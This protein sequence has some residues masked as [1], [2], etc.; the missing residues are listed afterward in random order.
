M[1]QNLI[2]LTV[3]LALNTTLGTSYSHED[4]RHKK[5]EGFW[6]RTKEPDMFMFNPDIQDLADAVQNGRG[7]PIPKEIAQFGNN[8]TG[9]LQYIKN[10]VRRSTHGAHP[11]ATMSQGQFEHSISH[12]VN[13]EKVRRAYMENQGGYGEY[14]PEYPP[15][16]HYESHPHPH[17]EHPTHKKHIYSI[18]NPFGLPPA[19][20]SYFHKPGYHGVGHPGEY[21]PSASHHHG[22]SMKKKWGY[23]PRLLSAL[24]CPCDCHDWHCFWLSYLFFLWTLYLIYKWSVQLKMPPPVAKWICLWLAWFCIKRASP[25]AWQAV[26]WGWTVSVVGQFQ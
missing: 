11:P 10:R 13:K 18:D 22:Q 25:S 4:S 14:H 1:K 7:Y 24:P 8:L 3:L 12:I 20:R 6:K 16:H 9:Y 2:A 23:H 19:H 5:G 26:V 17:H 15:E 21:V